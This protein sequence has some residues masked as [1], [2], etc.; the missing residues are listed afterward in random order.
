[1]RPELVT[2][3]YFERCGGMTEPILIPASLNP[4]PPIPGVE[5]QQT[6]DQLS[7]SDPQ[8]NVQ[9]A[10]QW[11]S[12]DY[13][14]DCVRDDG[15]DKLDMVIPQG[16]TVRKVA[17]LYGPE[18]K[19]EVI[20]V[21]RQEGAAKGWNMRQWADYYEA[22]GEKP[23]RNVISLEVSMSKLGRLIRRPKVVRDLDL[24]DSVWPQEDVAKGF[25]P[26]V[27]FYCLMSVAD[28]YTD[29]HIDFGGSSV[30]YHIL[31]G[32]KTFFFIP[33]K[34][35]HLKKYEEWC[36][37][38]DQNSIFLGDETKECYRV[39]LTEGDTML[40]PSGWIHAVW[41]PETSLVIGG[42]FLTRLHYG[43]QIQINDIEK[44]TNVARKYR[45]PYFQRVMWFAVLQY[46]QQDP[47]PSTV[48]RIL[49]DGQKFCRD[50][51]V[52][53][54]FGSN[55]RHSDNA[56][57]QNARFYSQGEIDGLQDLVRYIFRTVLISLGKM[58]G[59]TK[60]TQDAVLKSMPK[61]VGEH[62]EV[63]KT[64]ALW[65]AWKRG[66]E[67]L[68][69]WAHPDALL[70]KVETIAGGRR[71]GAVP[72]KRKER[73]AALNAFITTSER[74]SSRH[75]PKGS[76]TG[77]VKPAPVEQTDAT[78]TSITLI[79]TPS[80]NSILAPCRD[81]CEA[82][83]KQSI[84]CEHHE[85]NGAIRPDPMQRFGIRIVAPRASSIVETPNNIELP[86]VGSERVLVS[87]LSSK[88][89]S[90]PGPLVLLKSES[91]TEMNA[92]APRSV[93]IAQTPN[94]VEAQAATPNVSLNIPVPHPHPTTTSNARQL[95]AK[96]CLECRKSKVSSM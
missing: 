35:Q 22:E 14:Y 57:Y 78:A 56:D 59:V 55:D 15:Q 32:K 11:F 91:S 63:A 77:L 67:E 5:E 50:V 41:T 94:Q 61:G 20:D 7:L 81:S 75:A 9:E 31:K 58:Q 44:N 38:R 88:F 37:S 8:S 89:T 3:E 86:N 4:R 72:L 92:R 68:P 47:V 73:Q 36:L 82:C 25:Y 2:I 95:R 46:V 12:E 48:A 49:F 87:P 90:V 83:R 34:K 16:L 54:E 70:S 76:E 29:F 85:E 17:E 40:I 24:Q 23:V 79:P 66:N 80:N 43:M 74:R 84:R 60:G 27:Q 13:D 6:L 19:V 26:K 69:Q 53:Y 52:Y 51:P 1:M 45:Y 64:F 30:Y 71:K 39:D 18:E 10:T 33:P 65:A 21:K 28:C 93:D 62:L 96:A 42:N